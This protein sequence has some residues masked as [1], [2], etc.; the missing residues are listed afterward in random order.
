MKE[1]DNVVKGQ[2]LAEFDETLIASD[3]RNTKDELAATNKDITRTKAE[4]NFILDKDF[5]RHC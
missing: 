5:K 3:F 2:A 1:G 4:L